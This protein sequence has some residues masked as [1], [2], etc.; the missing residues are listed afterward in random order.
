MLNDEPL[1]LRIP[2]PAASYQLG[3]LF[4]IPQI[5]PALFYALK[6]LKKFQDF[7]TSQ[8]QQPEQRSRTSH[9]AR[10]QNSTLESLDAHD[11]RAVCCWQELLTRFEFRS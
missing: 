6:T 7:E 8:E 4:K 9:L 2:E 5:L 10:E 3:K 1:D 11:F